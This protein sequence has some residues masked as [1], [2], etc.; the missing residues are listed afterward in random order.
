MTKKGESAPKLGATV[1]VES[2]RLIAAVLTPDPDR[3]VADYD[4][5]IRRIDALPVADR[6]TTDR[7][8]RRR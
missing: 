1:S 8:I 5:L 6:T 7:P 2:A 4:D 3:R